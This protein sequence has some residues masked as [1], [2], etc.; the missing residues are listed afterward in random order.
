MSQ[1]DKT[2]HILMRKPEYPLIVISKDHLMSA[3][4]IDELAYSCVDAELLEGETVIKAIDSTAEEFWYSPENYFISPGW[5]IKRWTK[6]RIIQL[7][8]SFDCNEVK[9]SEKSIS[10]NKLDRII[11]DICNLLKT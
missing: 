5:V 10:A 2:F 1:E 11:F 3:F 4:D 8:N 6:K 9:Y 7:Y